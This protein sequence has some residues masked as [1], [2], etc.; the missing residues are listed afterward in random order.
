MIQ[1]DLRRFF[2]WVV[3][4]PGSDP[5]RFEE[6]IF[7]ALRNSHFWGSKSSIFIGEYEHHAE[8]S[9]CS[10]N[11][12]RIF[13]VYKGSLLKNMEKHR[14]FPG[15]FTSTAMLDFLSSKSY[16]TIFLE[17]NMSREL[18]G[19]GHSDCADLRLLRLNSS[20]LYNKREKFYLQ[21][22]YNL[23]RSWFLLY[24]QDM[25]DKDYFNK[26]LKLLFHPFLTWILTPMTKHR[27]FR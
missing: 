24:L 6:E 26:V 10:S 14:S 12:C 13:V 15:K 7:T 27:Y 20:L 3:Q 16:C 11:W 21:S 4:P 9:F 19:A 5:C 18:P 17:T 23:S 2:N 22:F 25:K 1:I 8:A